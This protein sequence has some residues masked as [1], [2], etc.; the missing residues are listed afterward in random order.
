MAWKEGLAGAQVALC[1]NNS[2]RFI[3]KVCMIKVQTFFVCHIIDICLYLK[4]KAPIFCTFLILNLLTK[5]GYRSK[6]I[7]YM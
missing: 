7:N 2:I 4:G 6:L 3:S 1:Q 5:R